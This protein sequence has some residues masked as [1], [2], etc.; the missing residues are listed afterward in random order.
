MPN[1]SYN[2][3]VWFKRRFLLKGDQRQELETFRSW[4]IRAAS[5]VVH[6]GRQW[7]LDLGENYP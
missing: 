4:F 1:I 6:T 5:R 7:F 3:F 2:L